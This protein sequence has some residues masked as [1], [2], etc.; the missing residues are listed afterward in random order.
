MG[1]GRGGGHVDGGG[2]S[3]DLGAWGGNGACEMIIRAVALSGTGSLLANGS[4]GFGPNVAGSCTDAAGDTT[5]YTVT[6]ANSG[7]TAADGATAKDLPGQGL[8]CP[9]FSCSASLLPI[10][11]SCPAAASWPNLLTAGGLAISVFPAKS[12]VA[13]VVNCNVTATG[14]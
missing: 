11:A 9:V 14:Q 10:P 2:T 4:N 5:S 1:G 6:F 7:A 13:F 8:S 12:S 3:C